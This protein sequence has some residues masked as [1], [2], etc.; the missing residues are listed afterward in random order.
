MCGLVWTLGSKDM[1]LRTQSASGVCPAGGLQSLLG[2]W[3]AVTRSDISVI[4]HWQ[5][6]CN[7]RKAVP[8]TLDKAVI[9]CDQMW[10]NVIKCDQM[11]SNVIKCDQMWS[12]YY[13]K[14]WIQPAYNL[15]SCFPKTVWHLNLGFVYWHTRNHRV[16]IQANAPNTGYMYI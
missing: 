11:W 3:T 16:Q 6:C 10:S 2:A 4:K 15:S 9:K 14:F 13:A 12:V 5:S 1:M 8:T 7:V